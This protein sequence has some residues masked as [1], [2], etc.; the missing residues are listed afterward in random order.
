MGESGSSHEQESKT[1]GQEIAEMLG[2]TFGPDIGFD[3][4][5]IAELSTKPFEEAF[6]T[7][8]SYLSQA[9]VDPDVALAPWV[10]EAN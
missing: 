1:P 4:E 9:G 3:E 7:A 8:Y 2:S 10:E 5:T 6:E